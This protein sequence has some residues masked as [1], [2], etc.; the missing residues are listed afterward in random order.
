MKLLDLQSNAWHSLSLENSRSTCHIA[1][2]EKSLVIESNVIWKTRVTLKPKLRTYQNI[3]N[4]NHWSGSVAQ[5]VECWTC[6]Q[7][8]LDS[9]PASSQKVTDNILGQDINLIIVSPH[10]G[11]NWYWQVMEVN[12]MSRISWQFIHPRLYGVLLC[13]GI[14]VNCPR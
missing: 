13:W 5:S 10:Q 4:C 9:T 11:V 2:L 12:V 8:A 7:V 6:N 14:T 1:N 3:K